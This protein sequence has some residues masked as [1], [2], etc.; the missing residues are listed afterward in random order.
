[1]AFFILVAI[2]AVLS[3]IVAF[4]LSRCSQPCAT[5]NNPFTTDFNDLRRLNN[6]A[7]SRQA[8]TLPDGRKLFFAAYGADTGPTIFFLHGF[9]DCRLTGAFFDEPGQKLG[10][11]I[12]A[13]DRPGIG[14]SSPQKHRTVLDHAEDVRHLAAHLDTKTYSVVSGGGG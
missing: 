11:R 14:L 5:P 4:T 6:S 7:S 12:I 13:V 8:Y 3:A 1:M 2:T 10:A 9:G